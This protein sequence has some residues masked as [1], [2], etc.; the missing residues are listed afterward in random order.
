L[1]LKDNMDRMNEVINERRKMLKG[2]YDSMMQNPEIAPRLKA[3]GEYCEKNYGRPLSMIE[4][5]TIAQCMQ[6]AIDQAYTSGG[7]INR[8]LNEATTQSNVDFL[9]IQLPLIAALLPS[10][11]MNE[12]AATQP[13]ERRTGAVAYLDWYYGQSKGGVTS[14]DKMIGAKTGHA[15]SLS[16]RQYARATVVR[17][18]IGTGTGV[19]SSTTAYTP[20]LSNLDNVIVEKLHG[21]TYTTIATCTTAGVISGTGI[22]G[23][24]NTSGV[25]SITVSSGVASTDS[26]LLTYDYL[27]EFP[28]NAYNEKVGVPEVTLD[29]TTST[30][31][32][33]DYPIRAKWSLASQIDA[34]KV[35]GLDMEKEFVKILGNEVKF[36]VDQRGLE[37]VHAAAIDTTNNAGTIDAW[38]ARP[39]EGETW[40]FKKQEFCDRFIQGSNLIQ[41]KTLRA[42]GNVIV[43]GLDVARVL[44][45]L[46]SD[47]FKAEKLSTP[48]TGPVKIGTLMDQFTVVQ[49]PFMSDT[50]Y[51]M[52][53]KGD[54][55]LMAG[56]IYLPYIPLFASPTITTSDLMSQKGFLTS[57]AYKVTNPGMF[58]YGTV[59]HLQSGYVVG[60]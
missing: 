52:M 20:G 42:V 41:K 21:S 59:T 57:A 38:D 31:E 23:T 27:Y 53:Y 34:Q 58:T 8:V 9:G 51:D 29:I 15:T 13:L 32:A 14:S 33:Q 19:K 43:C 60:S 37:L 1:E 28:V 55:Y 48:P 10:L 7:A 45:Q 49:N 12:I 26:I 54:N 22:S 18:V 50:Y 39:S 2:Q 4:R 30:V 40:A 5:V 44:R 6:N 56:F 11:V 46:G 25:Y 17:E 35:Y 24:I 36:S 47:F 16:G 3:A